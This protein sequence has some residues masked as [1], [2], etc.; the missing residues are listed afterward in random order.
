MS[1]LPL[2]IQ[3]ILDHENA[4][5]AVGFD[6]VMLWELEQF[7]E[8]RKLTEAHFSLLAEKVKAEYEAGKQK[9][10]DVELRRKLTH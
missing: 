4:T 9:I 7:E 6:R 10:E 8:H 3:Q 5:I 2:H 1:K